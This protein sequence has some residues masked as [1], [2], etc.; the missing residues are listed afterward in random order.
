MFTTVPFQE[1]LTRGEQ[2]PFRWTSRVATV[3]LSNHQRLTAEV[4]VRLDGVDLA[5][6]RGKGEMLI[7]VQFTDIAGRVYQDHGSIDLEKIQE[8]MKRSD[9]VYS[10]P[11]FVTPGDYEVTVAILDTATNEHAIRKQSAHVAPLKSD[12]LPQAWRDLPSVEFIAATEPP[13]SWY[14]PAV[15]GKLNLPLDTRQEVRIEVIVNLTPSE[16]ASGSF[17]V[18]DRNLSAL[19]PALK[20]ISQIEASKATLNVSLLDLTRRKV[21]FRQEDV[22]EL[23]WSKMRGSLAEATPGSIDVKSLEDRGH[24]A[25]FFVSEVARR[26]ASAGE[27]PPVVIVLSSPVEFEQGADLRPINVSAVESRVFYIR[28]H[29]Q[30]ER[31]MIAARDPRMIGRARIGGPPGG[32]GGMQA[33][34]VPIDQLEPTLKPLNPELFDVQTAEEFRKAL[35]SLMQEVSRL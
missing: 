35:A 17:R 33:P 16:Q 19:L 25:A 24:N 3:Y 5:K 6:R 18:Q 21:V 28:Y 7:L 22:H 15:K 20:A 26:I 29:A 8:S 13:D 27:K 9:V 14:R 10:Q 11:V 31:R 30:S 1:W 32:R 12:P 34:H 2:G 23:D 4:E